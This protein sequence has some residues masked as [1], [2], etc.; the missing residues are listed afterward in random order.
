MVFA[1]Y[2]IL[3]VRHCLLKGHCFLL[4]Q[5]ESWVSGCFCWA[6]S[7]VFLLCLC[8]SALIEAVAYFD[9]V[10]IEQFTKFMMWRKVLSY[11]IE[12]II[13]KFCF[14]ISTKWRVKPNNISFSVSFVVADI[15]V[16]GV[17]L[18]SLPIAGFF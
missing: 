8:I 17:I 1:W 9:C 10:T 6:F 7:K 14:D 16:W 11:K 5:F 12:K 3:S 15:F 18:Q 4:V 13:S 2:T